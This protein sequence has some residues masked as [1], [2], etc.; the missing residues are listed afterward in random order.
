MHDL[1]YKY[2]PLPWSVIFAL[3][4]HSWTDRFALSGD[5]QK[6]PSDRILS[7]P[8]GRCESDGSDRSGCRHSCEL[9]RGT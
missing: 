7:P 2:R 5:V 3:Q 4:M 6:N 8:P 9:A 1:P